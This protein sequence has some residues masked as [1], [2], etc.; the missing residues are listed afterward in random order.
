M[1]I[2]SPAV[3]LP[4]GMDGRFG[5]GFIEALESCRS[6]NG[7]EKRSIEILFP[8]EMVSKQRKRTDIAFSCKNEK[9]LTISKTVKEADTNDNLLLLF[10]NL[11][12]M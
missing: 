8:L 6:C 4:H 1:S 10:Y 9:S 11:L 3:Q 12:R 7:R 5:S 2:S